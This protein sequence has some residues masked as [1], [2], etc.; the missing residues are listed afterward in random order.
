MLCPLRSIR[1]FFYIVFYPSTFNLDLFFL[2]TLFYIHQIIP[3]NTKN[4][5]N[6]WSRW[7]N[8]NEALWNYH[9][10]FKQML[11]LTRVLRVFPLQIL[12]I[13]RYKCSEQLRINRRYLLQLLN[14]F[15]FSFP[16]LKLY[17]TTLP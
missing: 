3:Q 16:P 2:V 12:Y 8:F 11:L 14:H 4:I 9:N 7:K 10:D 1:T 13:K 5:S 15:P 6:N 17:I